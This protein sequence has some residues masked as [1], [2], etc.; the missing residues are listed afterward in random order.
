M[1]PKTTFWLD[2]SQLNHLPHPPVNVT[3]QCV[4][5]G[6]V[7]TIYPGRGQRGDVEYGPFGFVCKPY[8]KGMRNCSQC[9]S[10]SYTFNY[11]TY[12]GPIAK[13]TKCPAGGFYQDEAGRR[14]CKL[15]VNGTYVSPQHNPGTNPL[16]CSVCPTGTN[17]TVQAGHRA[18]PCLEGYYRLQRFGPCRACNAT[19]PGFACTNDYLN[20]R[21]GYWWQW[22][23]TSRGQ[24]QYVEFTRDIDLAKDTVNYDQ[25]KVNFTQEL[26]LVY[27]CPVSASC[28]GGV[29]NE[30]MCSQGYKGPLCSLCSDG[31]FSWFNTCQHCPALWRSILQILFIVLLVIAFFVALF[32]ADKL[33]MTGVTTVVDQ[34][35]SKAKII[36]GFVQVMSGVLSAL[37]YVPWPKV[38]LAVGS[39]VK[40]IELQVVEMANPTCINYQLRFNSLQKTVA[41]I[42][43]QFIVILAIVVYYYV[44]YRILPYW[45][46]TLRPQPSTLSLARRSCLRNSWWIMFLCYPSTTA[47]IMATLPYKPWTCIKLCLYN[48]QQDCSWYLK[49]DMS[50]RCNFNRDDP[51]R[52]LFIISWVCTFYV[53]SLPFILLWGLYK[54]HRKAV[55]NV[56]PTEDEQFVSLRD[57]RNCVGHDLLQSIEFLDENYEAKFWFWELLEISRKFLLICAIEYF[58]SNSLSGVAIAALIANLFLLFHAQFKPIKRKSEHWLQ[59]LSLLVISLSLMLGT[60][61]TLEEAT[62]DELSTSN[63]DDRLVFSIILQLIHAAFVIYLI[64]RLV[65]SVYAAVKKVRSTNSPCKIVN[66][67]I[68]LFTEEDPKHHESSIQNE[69]NLPS[70]VGD[71]TTEE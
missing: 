60:L 31:Y 10:G 65:R 20:V 1:S 54:R 19:D 57:R 24:Q 23:H 46:E 15:C 48:T 22:N 16:D 9:P 55:G 56:D 26:P 45:W 59:L 40:N 5:T 17:T 6:G 32:M 12:H 7:V 27:R 29:T 14:S 3:I 13:C 39:W 44:R 41:N 28:Q 66:F 61:I 64:G 58:G 8:N 52:V 62:S 25:T 67:F 68:Y 37:S 21:S 4:K 34:I 11:Q 63:D 2:C 33:R 35:A 43:V 49:T 70:L 36:V 30:E 69:N 47:N 51:N 50:I 18:C 53:I 71:E 42:C 38:L